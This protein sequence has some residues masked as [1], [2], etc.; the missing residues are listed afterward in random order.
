MKRKFKKEKTKTFQ[1]VHLKVETKKGPFENA[2]NKNRRFTIETSKKHFLQVYTQQGMK[3]Q[4][5]TNVLKR[6]FDNGR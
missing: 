6:A 4:Q 5:K 2:F 3:T 1:K